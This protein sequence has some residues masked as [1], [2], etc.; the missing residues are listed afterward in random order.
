MLEYYGFIN[1]KDYKTSSIWLHC[2][3]IG[4]VRSIKIFINELR[5]QCPY[6]NIIITT[7]TMGGKKI[8]QKEIENAEVFLLPIE[9]V[10][11]IHKI[12]KKFNIKLLLIVETE[13]WPNLIN[14]ASKYCS[15]Y[16]INARL[17]QKSY[18]RYKAFSCLFKKLLSKFNGIYAKDKF[19]K[20]LLESISQNHVEQLGNIKFANTSVNIDTNIEKTFLNKKC[21]FLASTHRGEED[22]FIKNS[23]KY[24][25]S[26]DHIFIAPRHINRIKEIGELLSKQNLSY[27]IFSIDKS[28]K[29]F[30]LID[31]FGVMDTFYNISDKIF[32]GGSL[33]N[34][35]GHNIYEALRLKKIIA[36]GPYMDNFS[37]IYKLALSFELLYIVNN[38]DNFITYLN[39]N[40]DIDYIDGK[41][42][43]F[44]GKLEQ[45]N[46]EILN[47]LMGI[48]KSEIEKP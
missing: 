30:I 40:I 14:T 31:L 18:K 4:E 43:V 2:A 36:T 9:N 6:L 42:N 25:G 5:R 19:D 17:S 34:I 46:K 26:F 12:I 45:K 23:Y 37:D 44:L 7:T 8:A 27:S 33:V 35:G 22:F 21:L 41:F 24:M 47:N 20:I 39:T 29:K 32:I 48:V 28:F 1:Y 15:L 16:L 11:A 10:L 13:L 3:S 38:V